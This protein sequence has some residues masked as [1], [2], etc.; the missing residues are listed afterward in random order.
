VDLANSS[1]EAIVQTLFH[2]ATFKVEHQQTSKVGQLTRKSDD[3]GILQVKLSQLG[4][5]ADFNWHLTQGVIIQPQLLQVRH[6][7][8]IWA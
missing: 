1:A 6:I 4:A 2:W 3:V 7:L 5:V 8:N